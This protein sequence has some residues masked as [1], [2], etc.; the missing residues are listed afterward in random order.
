MRVL[1]EFSRDLTDVQ[2]PHIAPVILSE[3]YRIF[4]DEQV[5]GML[6]ISE[7]RFY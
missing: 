2:L 1:R 4:S 3:M 5:R 7:L 6:E